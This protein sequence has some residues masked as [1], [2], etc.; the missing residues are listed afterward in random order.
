MRKILSNKRGDGYIE[1]AVAVLVIAFILLLVISV[2]SLITLKQDMRYMCSELIDTATK[3]GKVGSEVYS[4][5]SELC[6]ESGITPEIEFT[7]AYFDTTSGKVQ[8]GD[9][10]SCKLTH[11]LVLKGFGGFTLPI[12]VTV[13][14]SGLSRIYWK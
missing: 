14:Q 12:S 10:I 2:W 5:F 6:A 13:E 9:V 3:T 7:A 11:N 4:R 1:I 8:L